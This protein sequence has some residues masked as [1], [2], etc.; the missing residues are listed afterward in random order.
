MSYICDTQPVVRDVVDEKAKQFIRELLLNPRRLFAWWK[1]QHTVTVQLQEQQLQDIATVEAK[2]R[3]TTE[4]YHRTLDRLTDNLDPDEVAYYA[5]QRDNLKELIVEYREELER[6]LAKQTNAEVSEEVITGFLEMGQDYRY[7][8]EHSTD[9]TFWRGL[10]DDLDIEAQIGIEEARRYIEFIVFGKTRKR[11]YLTTEPFNE[12]GEQSQIDFGG[13]KP[14]APSIRFST[15][16]RVGSRC[17]IFRRS[18]CPGGFSGVCTCAQC[19]KLAV[20]ARRS[21]S[22]CSIPRVT[23]CYRRR[24][25]ISW[26]SP[27]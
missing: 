11:F 19:G 15:T 1:E 16:R 2:I 14:A 21:L 4:K 20:R 27:H 5:Q 25:A 22:R 26:I 8:L 12:S 23:R 17:S 13:I 24:R 10:V 3:S 7:A 9:F 6:L 18:G